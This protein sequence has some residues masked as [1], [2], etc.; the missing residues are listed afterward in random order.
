MLSKQIDFQQRKDEFFL[1][2]K[3]LNNQT[4]KNHE[5]LEKILY[6]FSILNKINKFKC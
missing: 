5:N 1:L 4:Q 6:E 3:P 2:N